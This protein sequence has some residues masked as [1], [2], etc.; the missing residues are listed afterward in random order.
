MYPAERTARTLS[1]IKNSPL[2]NEKSKLP[3]LN[4]VSLLTFIVILAFSTILI[5]LSGYLVFRNQ[6]QTL[7]DEK[8]V[9]LQFIAEFKIQQIL[10][11]NQERMADVNTLASS[12]L[13]Q[14]II[15]QKLNSPQPSP[16]LLSFNQS[17]EQFLIQ[18]EYESIL[19]ASTDDEIL[20]SSWET[21]ASLDPETK[22]L[23]HKVG[24]A[25]TP[26]MG[27]FFYSQRDKKIALELAAPVQAG[28]DNPISVLV[29]RVD[30]N[31][32][33]YP[34]IQ[35]WP[36]ESQSAETLIVRQQGDS[37][38]FLNRLRNSDAEPL[39]LSIPLSEL[40]VPAVQAISGY[41]GELRGNDYRGVE[42][43]AQ[44]NP[45]PGTPWFMISKVDVSELQPEIRS[46]LL[47]ILMIVG[48][49]VLFAAVLAGYY[50]TTRQK[51]L[52]RKLLTV[53]RE[54]QIE[55][56]LL[57]E[58]LSSSMDEIYIFDAVTYRFR[59]V[60]EGALKNLG[61]SRDQMMYMTPLD[62]KPEIS[63]REFARL[64]E[65][66]DSGKTE[67]VIFETNHQRADHSRYPVEVHVQLFNYGSE[68]VY[69][70]VIQ[71]IT[72]RKIAETKVKESYEKYRVLF[73]TFPLG[74]IVT[75]K[76]RR[77]V[78]VNPVAERI[79]DVPATKLIGFDSDSIPLM[80]IDPD[81]KPYN[82][83]L[84]PGALEN[85][86]NQSINSVEIGIINQS[87]E[88]IRVSVTTAPIPLPAYG[89]LL[90]LEDVTESRRVEKELLFSQERYRYL[91]DL[92]PN[93]IFVSHKERIE[94]INDAGVILFGADKAEQLIGKPVYEVFHPD[95]HETIRARLKQMIEEKQA[96]PMIHEKIIRLDGS[97][98]DVE[99][100]A[101]PIHD[102][103]GVTIQVILRDIS[104]RIQAEEKLQNQISEL[105]RWHEV[106]LGRE[107][108]ILELKDEV[109][110]CLRKAGLPERYYSDDKTK[111]SGKDE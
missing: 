75:D 101:V 49:A 87:G 108:R 111:A 53:E 18:N 7:I 102:E 105:Q 89:L 109:N 93:A 5:A 54:A 55:H 66:L 84:F 104:E 83:E 98:R 96:V 107:K 17:M 42:V 35:S 50:I 21:P 79:I 46:L 95:Y 78:E 37:V 32:Y 25:G 22:D 3:W 58:T 41:Q 67:R 100:A 11:W 31:L 74:L 71:D 20:Y 77:I 10:R 62:I 26:I 68:R 19:V 23:I 36:T 51:S 39:S 14:E 60:N 80:V 106:T 33:L 70:A 43:I 110:S 56:N 6:R 34:L 48:L 12:I 2:R 8:Y 63:E 47:N 85:L 4:Q 15:A 1:S 82:P 94:F 28:N 81:G 52:F 97:L 64:L 40:N 69:L 13:L 92:S 27:D 59:S 57:S 24:I 45:I 86:E 44:A 65:P 88:T 61:Y 76:K 9:D 90:I 29:L 30:P 103:R 91:V 16:N 38:L 99:V 72:E 73:Q